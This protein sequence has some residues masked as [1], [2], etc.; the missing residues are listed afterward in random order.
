MVRVPTD[1]AIPRP[2]VLMDHGYNSLPFS[3]HNSNSYSLTSQT[4]MLQGSHMSP[5]PVMPWGGSPAA[6]QPPTWSSPVPPGGYWPPPPPAGH[7]GQSSSTAPLPSGYGYWP[8]P[9]WAPLAGR[10]APPWGMSP[11]TTLTSQPHQHSSSP[12]MVSH[13]CLLSIIPFIIR[14]NAKRLAYT[15]ISVFKRP[16]STV[17]HE[18]VDG[19]LNMGGSGEGKGSGNDAAAS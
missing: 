19:A 16:S 14:A 8:P 17:G 11:R 3:I 10:H 7:L 18:F 1:P 13:S 6:G 12:P 2:H 15:S 4:Y 5:P 9:S